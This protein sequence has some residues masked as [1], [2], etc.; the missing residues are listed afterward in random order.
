MVAWS[1]NKL[2]VKLKSSKMGGIM[3]QV[4]LSIGKYLL[5]IAAVMSLSG[6]SVH[7]EDKAYDLYS[8]QKP[9][10]GYFCYLLNTASPDPVKAEDLKS[11][12]DV[13]C[14]RDQLKNQ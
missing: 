5:A 12:R 3:R 10:A 7:A 13:V 6:A 1:K 8:W 2:K 9:G 11:S 14:G 4:S